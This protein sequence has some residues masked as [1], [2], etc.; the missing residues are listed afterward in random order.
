[1]QQLKLSFVL[2]LVSTIEPTDLA[3]TGALSRKRKQK[4]RQKSKLSQNWYIKNTQKNFIASMGPKVLFSVSDFII[5]S[6]SL[7]Q[8]ILARS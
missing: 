7:F 1:M 3:K 6:Y 4:V 2:F 5:V 8:S